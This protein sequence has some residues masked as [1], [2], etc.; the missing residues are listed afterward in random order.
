MGPNSPKTELLLTN[1]LL[2]VQ[3]THK[4]ATV[5][6]SSVCLSLRAVAIWVLKC[7]P[8]KYLPAQVFMAVRSYQVP[9]PFKYTYRTVLGESFTFSGSWFLFIKS[10]RI[11]LFP[12]S[13]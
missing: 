6:G 3:E 4:A 1:A 5:E 10:E 8:R 7:M 11:E 12:S 2:V 9:P 13:L